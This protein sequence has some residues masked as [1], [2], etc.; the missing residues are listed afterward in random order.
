MSTVN[1]PISSAFKLKAF[2]LAR[3]GTCHRRGLA[4]AGSLRVSNQ[5]VSQEGGG[6]R[7]FASGLDEGR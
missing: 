4:A 2:L 1:F 6:C 5:L 7:R 3:T